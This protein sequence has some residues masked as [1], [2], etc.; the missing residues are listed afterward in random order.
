MD[1][2]GRSS[3]DTTTR[4]DSPSPATFQARRLVSPPLPPSV[5]FLPSELSSPAAGMGRDGPLPPGAEEAVA[6]QLSEER[7][8]EPHIDNQPD[9]PEGS[10]DSVG[11]C[12]H[13]P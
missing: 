2:G 12:H 1:V 13:R 5:P 7:G 10:G 6:G 11:P 9:K 4:L 3:T 8:G